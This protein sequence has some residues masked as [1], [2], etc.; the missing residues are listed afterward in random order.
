MKKQGK[1]AE[2]S[3]SSK[4]RNSWSLERWERPLEVDAYT[5]PTLA[6][7]GE[8]PLAEL[9]KFYKIVDFCKITLYNI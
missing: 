5:N 8:S 2:I 3:G 6:P 1:W 7:N 9:E 4:I